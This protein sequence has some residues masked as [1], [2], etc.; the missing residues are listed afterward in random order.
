M[1]IRRTFYLDKIQSVLGKQVIKVLLGMRRVGK[2]TLLMQIQ[3]ELI[4]QGV[5]KEQIISINFEWMQFEPIKDY[6]MLNKY[7]REKM[8][9]DKKYYVFLDELQEVSGF[10]KVV[11]SL[12]AEGIAEVFITGSNSRLL[13]GELATYLTGRFY[14]IEVLPLSFSE[15]ISVKGDDKK[16]EVFLSYLRAGGMPGT[17]QF[18]DRDTRKNYLMDMYHSILLRDIVKRHNIR[19]VEL[20]QR[21]MMYMMRNI[22][23]IFSA[24]SITKYLK[25]EGRRLS[26]ET[27]YNYIDA[28][29]SAFLVHG[30]PRY[31]IKGKE[32][33]K[34]NEKYFMN[35]LG[36]RS[37]YFN[38]E[39]DIGQALENIVYLEL[40]RRGYTIYIGKLE[41]QE[42]DFIAEKGSNKIYI[43]VAYLLAEASTIE[44]EFSV[45]EAIADNHEKL[46]LSMDKVDRSRNGIIHKNI[47]DFLLQ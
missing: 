4:K 19:D 41:D 9:S 8:V 21:F 46:V 22:S 16:D 37:I 14:S 31:N 45:L 2:S 34:T 30:I 15:L 26:K 7:I 29:K 1:Q 6:T 33:L 23:Q 25:N 36:F 24:V 32:I 42:V 11:N 3:E 10:E 18:E 17:L 39:Q 43:Q 5:A 44:R 38:N 28:A 12:N 20:L 27:I 40:R 35:D 47:V 13:S